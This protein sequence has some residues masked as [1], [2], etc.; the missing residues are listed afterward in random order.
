M[1]ST[2]TAYRHCP[3]PSDR[4]QLSWV[5]CGRWGAGGGR[6]AAGGE[7]TCVQG[8]RRG[9]VAGA[10]EVG[11]AR[12]AGGERA[13]RPW[14]A[15]AGGWVAGRGA[16]ECAAGG[17]AVLA[18]AGCVA[19]GVAGDA[20]APGGRRRPRRVSHQLLEAAGRGVQQPQLVL[21]MPHLLLPR[22]DAWPREAGRVAA[23]RQG[24][25]GAGMRG[26]ACGAA[27]RGRRLGPSPALPASPPH[28]PAARRGA[29]RPAWL[30]PSAGGLGSAAQGR[31]LGLHPPAARRRVGAAAAP[32]APCPA[33]PPAPAPLR[34]PAQPG[35]P[36]PA[37]ACRGCAP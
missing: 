17:P 27:A 35:R 19:D 26:R 2:P 5:T 22:Q 29:G 33:A 18:A 1:S 14:A 9:W 28:R 23:L 7:G 36:P 34:C 30:L 4:R 37:A 3:A 12:G 10:A 6:R 24:G 25:D 31:G 16:R 20:C 21:N 11:T 13:G 8:S 32:A 15:A